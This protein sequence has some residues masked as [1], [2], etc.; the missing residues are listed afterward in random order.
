MLYAITCHKS[1][2]G[3]WKSVF[4]DQ[5]YFTDDMLNKEYLRWFYTSLTRSSDKLYL[6]NFS[7]KIF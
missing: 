3:Q 2:G 6:I 5:S 4:V 1:Q 7:D